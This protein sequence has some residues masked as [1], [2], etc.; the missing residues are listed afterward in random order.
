VSKI[1]KSFSTNWVKSSSCSTLQFNEKAAGHDQFQSS[2]HI[3]DGRIKKWDNKKCL[4]FQDNVDKENVFH[5]L[6]L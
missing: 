4:S 6:S 5:L 3:I 2:D 1:A